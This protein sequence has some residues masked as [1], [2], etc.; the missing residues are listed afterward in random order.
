MIPATGQL[1]DDVRAAFGRASSH[2]LVPLVAGIL[3]T[4]PEARDEAAHVAMA[5]AAVH[6]LPAALVDDVV[7]SAAA[8]VA[9][10]ENMH[11]HGTSS[12][13]DTAASILAVGRA[14]PE[15]TRARLSER[16]WAMAL[17]GDDPASLRAVPASA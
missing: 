8:S 4:D 12:T 10:L 6:H 13:V 16:G 1:P 5:L 14:L 15:A 17:A 7:S 11:R 9:L 2:L 3:A